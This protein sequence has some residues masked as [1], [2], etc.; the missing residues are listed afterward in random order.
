M[1]RGKK[2]TA[3]KKTKKTTEVS[4]EEIVDINEEDTLDA[5]KEEEEGEEIE[6]IAERAEDTSIEE[7]IIEIE[8]KKEELGEKLKA[9]PSIEEEVVEILEERLYV[10]PLGRV[11]NTPVKKR[12]KR[13]VNM[14]REFVIR[15]MKPDGLIIDPELNELIWRRGIEKPPRKIRIRVTKDREGLVTV[16]P[17][18]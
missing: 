8:E 14:L 10:V 15:H 2:K 17:V 7:E 9:I 12:S 1:P 18:D 16:Y 13:A 3:K 6:D 4:A 11:K 5:E